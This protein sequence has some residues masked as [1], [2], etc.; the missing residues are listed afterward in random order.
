MSTML[1][2]DGG[3]QPVTRDRDGRRQQGDLALPDIEDACGACA[4]G[5]PGRPAGD[6]A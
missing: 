2:A 6:G 5:T 4:N 1:R 3:L